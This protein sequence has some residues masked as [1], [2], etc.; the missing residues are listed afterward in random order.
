MSKQP[1]TALALADTQE[2]ESKAKA[3]ALEL[4]YE[5]SLA[6]G[7]LED[8][9]RFYQRRTVEDCLEMGKRLLV[10]KELTPHGEFAKRL[11]MLGFGADKAQRFMRSAAATTKNRNLRLL[12]E[13]TQSFASFWEVV[14]TDD[15]VIENIL[16]WDDV[17]RLSASELRRRVRDLEGEGG[18]RVKRLEAELEH[19]D[20]L[21]EKMRRSAPVQSFAPETH[22]AR[23]E[24]LAY[25]AE[26]Q[27]GFESL[28][29]LFREVAD[30]DRMHPEWRMRME[31]IWFATHA[32]LARGEACLKALRDAAPV[33][34]DELPTQAT[35]AHLLTPAEAE[36][37]ALEW[38]TMTHLAKTR[39][40]V[41][42][43]DRVTAL[44]KGR[45]RP[46]G[47]KNKAAA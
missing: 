46:A 20:A 13:K 4:G 12:S 45:G 28:S 5:G 39:A 14:M 33:L 30:Q 7:A 16:E 38:D 35:S 10:L 2:P 24:A 34:C 41:R 15:D 36:A 47:S 37:W 32:A 6:V 42:A 29:K 8:E 17:D 43:E 40:A 21:I 25:Q 11:E 9:I 22:A 44:P 26:V 18:K 27:I 1:K 19:R 3:L 31:Q 23:Q